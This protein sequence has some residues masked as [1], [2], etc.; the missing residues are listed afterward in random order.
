MMHLY[1]FDQEETENCPDNN[2]QKNL[3]KGF[4]CRGKGKAKEVA[5]NEEVQGENNTMNK[6]TSDLVVLLVG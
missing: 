4:G 5:D 3:E 2:N 6:P 1:L